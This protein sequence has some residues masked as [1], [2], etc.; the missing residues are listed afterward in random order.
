LPNAA[1]EPLRNCR[2]QYQCRSP[3]PT[4]GLKVAGR[5]YTRPCAEDMCKTIGQLCVSP[6]GAP[7]LQWADSGADRKKPTGW[8]PAKAR[9]T[10]QCR[11]GTA[12]PKSNSPPRKVTRQRGIAELKAPPNTGETCFQSARKIDNCAGPVPSSFQEPGKR[13][14][15]GIGNRGARQHRIPRIPS[16]PSPA[17]QL[18]QQSGAGAADRRPQD[19]KEPAPRA[20]AKS[21]PDMNRRPSKSNPDAP[22]ARG[23][24]HQTHRCMRP[25]RK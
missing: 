19:N 22:E 8:A 2:H 5:H 21:I 10:E 16:A 12:A 13:R 15:D 6:I 3:V 1:V 9:S 17:H 11:A 7:P 20:A 25:E 24:A 14:A 23:R 4:V 18:G